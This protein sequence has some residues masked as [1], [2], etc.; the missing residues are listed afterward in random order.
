MNL[1]CIL[2]AAIFLPVFVAVS[3]TAADMK[4]E[5]QLIWGTSEAKSPNPRHRPVDADVQR[6]LASLPLKWP[7]FFEENR[8]S[9]TVADAS[10]GKV[11]LSDRC[12]VEV[13][14]LGGDKIEVLLLGKGR[15][16]GKVTQHLP[17]GEILVLAGN[18][19]AESAWLV[20]LKRM[21]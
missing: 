3:A 16:V 13:K 17:R 9:F 6:K 7:H 5:A 15:E 4:L 2:M 8:K 1:K 20:T 19:P 18:A 21:E 12:A 14:N 11:A 10:A